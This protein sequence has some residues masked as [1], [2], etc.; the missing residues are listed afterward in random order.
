MATKQRKGAKS[1]KRKTTRAAEP[2]VAETPEAAP[3]LIAELAAMQL[4]PKIVAKLEILTESQ[5]ETVLAYVNQGQR[6]DAAYKRVVGAKADAA[7][8]ATVETPPAPAAETTP[9]PTPEATKPAAKMKTRKTKAAD[10]SKRLSAIDA[11]AKVLGEGSESMN[12]KK[13]IEEMG[14]RGYWTSPGGKTPHATLYS[15]ILREID[16]K[17]GKARF[18]KTDRGQFAY[19]AAAE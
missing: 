18:K 6:I 3:K 17:G 16:V 7:P 10:D 8:E 9:A 14:T 5:Q 15:A 4:A 11:A 19:N 13:L 1:A 12:C 2:Q